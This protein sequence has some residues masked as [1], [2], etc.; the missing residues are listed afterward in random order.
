MDSQSTT[1][2]ALPHVPKQRMFDESRQLLGVPETIDVTIHVL[3]VNLQE[4]QTDT[5]FHVRPRFF[6]EMLLLRRGLCQ[7]L[8]LHLLEH[9]RG[10]AQ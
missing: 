8:L 10:Q 6:R 7:T 4:D 1:V 5:A 2:I 3:F 9:L